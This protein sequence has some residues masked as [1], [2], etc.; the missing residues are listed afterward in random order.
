M[1]NLLLL[2]WGTVL[3]MYLSQVYMPSEVQVND[4]R[5]YRRAVAPY[6]ADLFTL[7]VIGWMAS[8]MFLRTSYNDTFNYISNFRRAE[9][10]SEYLSSL[11]WADW[12][13]NPLS[14]WYTR[15]IRSMTDNYHIYFFFPAVLNACAVVRLCKRYSINPAFSL[16]MF[17][18]VG[19]YLLCTAAMKQ[20]CAIA[21]LLFALPYAIEKRYVRFYAL[22]AVAVLL[23]TYALIFVIAP[24]MDSK[25][26]SKRT[27][28]GLGVVLFC[29]ATYGSTLGRIM[30]YA[31]SIGIDISEGE[32][33]DGHGIN[34]MRVLVYWTPG[35]IA[36]IFRERLF[37]DSTPAE[38][39]FVNM[40]ITSAFILTIGLAQ[41]ANLFARMAAYFEV[42]AIIAL[43]WMIRKLFN[44]KS[45]QF[46][47]LCA[48]VLYFGYFFYENAIN[49]QFE[50]GYH[51]ITP[52]QFIE[53]LFM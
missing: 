7:T 2:Y 38:H 15:V 32:L 5:L 3:L 6:R 35:V 33:F 49:T 31:G 27:W 46:V 39:F 51:A 40:S 36:L 44:R 43:P 30:E 25:P 20:C 8:F 50:Y 26:W 42:G 10:V 45:A 24:F 22:V 28:F 34:P 12:T 4:G 23:H 1:K 37:R 53:E 48:A 9:S 19:T 14:G 11:T 13:D 18:S 21:V 17:F 16:L 52:W 47:T 29:V 41:A